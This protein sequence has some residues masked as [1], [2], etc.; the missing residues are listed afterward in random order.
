[1][2]DEALEDVDGM[3]EDLSRREKVVPDGFVLMDGAATATAAGDDLDDF[4]MMLYKLSFDDL[5]FLCALEVDRTK[6]FE[7]MTGVSIHSTNP[8]IQ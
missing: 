7:T 1:V 4:G 6:S 2:E 8:A 3:D 5:L